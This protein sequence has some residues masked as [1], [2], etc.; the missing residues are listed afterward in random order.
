LNDF[1]AKGGAEEVY[2]T[3]VECLQAMPY[4][5][6]EHFDFSRFAD[7]EPP[8]P[9][10]W[11][12]A[13]ARALRQVL[14]RFRPERV[15]VH[16]YHNCL[17]PSVLATIARYKRLHGFTTYLTCHD[18][19]IVYYNPALLCY[20]NSTVGTMP[21]GHLGTS[22][23]LLSRAS[24]K[25]ALHDTLKKLYWH[26]MNTLFN[27][28]EVFDLFL[29]P[30]P[31]MQQAL[32]QYGIKNTVLV[33]NP[34]NV[35]VPLMP[36]KVTLGP[37]LNLAF[38]GRISSEKGLTQFID[39]LQEID[40]E[41]VNRLTVYGD[42]PERAMLESR[43]ATMIADGKLAFSGRL[44]HDALFSTLL[45]DADALALPSI[46]AENAPLA[47]VEAAMLGL[48]AL[49]HDV[50]SLTTFGSEIGN[51]IHYR[52]DAD[53]L[54]AALTQLARHLAEPNRRY[55]VGAYSTKR[56]AAR[57]TEVMRLNT[58]HRPSRRPPMLAP[59]PRLHA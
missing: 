43:F 4:V 50:G 7:G 23:A 12:V 42:G 34:V 8:G 27:P 52:S 20:D 44:P 15:L 18:Y 19:H 31:F 56:Y 30:S 25:G 57:L 46:C 40:C 51:K 5:E 33:L 53:S 9:H 37:K 26:T 39:L 35:D 11:N 13:A 48:P 45:R 6:V 1:T 21:L 55:D 58:A 36:A 24:A 41:R 2:R 28:N 10:A 17:S 54:R 49:V 14:E 47:I 32:S 38:V 29:C 16:N 22:R 59:L 3:S